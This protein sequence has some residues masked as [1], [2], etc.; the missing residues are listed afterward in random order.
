MFEDVYVAADTSCLRLSAVGRFSACTP[1]IFAEH[2][3]EPC[4]QMFESCVPEHGILQKGGN[5]VCIAAD[6]VCRLISG[7]L[8]YSAATSPVRMSADGAS[9][10]AS[11]PLEGDSMAD[12]N[13]HDACQDED[14][15][16]SEVEGGGRDPKST[17]GSDVMLAAGPGCGASI[18][19]Q[20]DE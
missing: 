16:S 19:R 11:H 13:G 8:R 7:A 18:C 5:E 10:S 2:Q 4:A 12:A 14:L 15:S 20:P 1:V 9:S 3:A 6:T 17:P